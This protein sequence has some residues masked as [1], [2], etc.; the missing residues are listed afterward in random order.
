MSARRL[1]LSAGL[2]L[3]LLA[4]A[5]STS[6]G[7]AADKTTTTTKPGKTTTTERVTTTT[8]GTDKNDAIDTI[9]GQLTG[10]D[11][12]AAQARCFAEAFVAE[13]SDDGI[14][15]VQ[16]DDGDPSDLSKD[17]R[18]VFIDSADGC[19]EVSDLAD[20]AAEGA[21][22]ELGSNAPLTG[23]EETCISANI[24]ARYSS[25][26][27]FL[28]EIVTED[29]AAQTVVSQAIGACIQTDSLKAL[30]TSQIGSRVDPVV[31]DCVAQA[32]IDQNGGTAGAFELLRQAGSG[33]DTTAIEDQVTTITQACVASN[34]AG[35]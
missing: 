4:P 20:R 16:A 25:S 10:G 14:E 35:G 8:E 30:I 33:G 17:D 3:T 23:N 2:A 18:A 26:G 15:V 27:Q 21:V 11:F 34:G 19:I 9:A 24:S 5:C 32:F 7:G 29:P 13:A 6:G 28:Y 22:E 12:T 1:L 31:A